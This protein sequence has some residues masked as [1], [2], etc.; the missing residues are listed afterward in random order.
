MIFQVHHVLVLY[1]EGKSIETK[2]EFS[3][4]ETTEE[5]TMHK[6]NVSN[7]LEQNW[8]KIFECLKD[9]S[10]REKKRRSVPPSSICHPRDSLGPTRFRLMST[11]AGANCANAL[12]PSSSSSRSHLAR[13][14]A[15]MLSYSRHVQHPA[16]GAPMRSSCPLQVPVHTSRTSMRL[17]FPLALVCH[18][19][20][21]A[22][23]RQC[24][25]ALLFKLPSHTSR[26]PMRLYSPLIIFIPHPGRR[27]ANTLKRSSFC[28][29]PRCADVLLSSSSLACGHPRPPTGGARARALLVLYPPVRLYCPLTRGLL[30]S[31]SLL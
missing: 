10:P 31:C 3:S 25:Q 8:I 22:A 20:H 27:C 21:P 7:I 30:T 1:A 23:V 14:N 6:F 13:A 16:S 29:I 9:I 28:I 4:H 26:A 24:A 5:T 19:P 15:L 2:Y 17:C 18:V 12:K 11:S